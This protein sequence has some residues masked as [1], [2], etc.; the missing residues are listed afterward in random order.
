MKNPKIKYDLWFGFGI[1]CII[2]TVMCL[3][4]LSNNFYKYNKTQR[5]FLVIGACTIGLLKPIDRKM[6]EWKLLVE[7]DEFGMKKKQSRFDFTKDEQRQIDMQQTANMERIIGKSTL[8]A[9]TKQ[10]SKNPEKDLNELIGLAPVKEKVN[11]MVARMKFEK[12]DTKSKSSDNALSGRHMVFYGSPGTGK[13]TVARIITGFLYQYHYIKENKVIEVDGNF[14]KA[15]SLGDTTIKTKMLIR[16]AYGGVLFIDE[17]YSLGESEFGEQAVAT[18]IKEMEDNRDKF[19]VILA[20]YTDNMKQLIKTNPGFASRI[21]EYISFPDYDEAEMRQIFLYMAGQ[22][23]FAIDQDTYDVFDLRMAKERPLM[24][25]GNAR[26]VRSI[27]DE[28]ID[29]HALNYMNKKISPANKF[30][31]MSCDIRTKPKDIF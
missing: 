21:K 14:L 19:I 3:L 26:T 11:E 29:L 20:G 28:A 7:Y 10:G 17:A 30:K 22:K 8:K 4:L 6:K 5:I 12:F 16:Q 13:T 2:N 18:L 25:F 9:I 27:L 1:L 24:T 15:G 31:L 23:N